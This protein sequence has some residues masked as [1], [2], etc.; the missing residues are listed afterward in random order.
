MCYKVSTPNKD[1]LQGYFEKQGVNQG[2]IYEVR[3]VEPHFHA[4]GFTMP[5]LPLT[6][7][8]EPNVVKPAMW[9][10]IPHWVR[11]EAEAKK[12]ANTL[13]ATREDIFEKASYKNYITKSRGLL[14]IN[15]FF[16]ANHPTAKT[17]VPYFI[18]AA[19]GDPFTL[20]CVCSN[21]LNEDTGEYLLTFSIITTPAN[22]LMSEIHNSK[23][24]MPLVIPTQS[25]EKWLGKLDKQSIKDMM[26]PLADGYLESYKV[27]N[28]IYKKGVNT[29]VPEILLRA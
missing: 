11:N 14:W 7:S 2:K 27:S 16:E 23:K 6:S 25:R 4:D 18:H 8:D 19:D 3:D 21:W 20:G 1:Q 24:R 17:T 13:N 29:N 10:L 15:G 5:I 12:Y 22:A 28:A 9:K 26:M